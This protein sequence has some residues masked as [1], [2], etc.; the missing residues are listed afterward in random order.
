MSYFRD[1]CEF[2]VDGVHLTAGVPWGKPYPF[3]GR[4]R[5]LARIAG[6]LKLRRLLS[7]DEAFGVLEDHR[8]SWMVTSLLL[9]RR[10]FGVRMD[11]VEPAFEGRTNYYTYRQI[12]EALPKASNRAKRSR[13]KWLIRRLQD[14]KLRREWN[15]ILAAREELRSIRTLL[16]HPEVLEFRKREYEQAKISQTL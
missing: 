1:S 3:G 4:I 6:Q 11:A 10:R 8:N 13:R 12:A 15:E 9:R 7:T 14:R 5:N 16:R 2:N